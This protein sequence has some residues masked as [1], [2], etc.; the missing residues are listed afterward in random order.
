VGLGVE[1]HLPSPADHHRLPNGIENPFVITTLIAGLA[2]V[3]LSIIIILSIWILSKP[4]KNFQR[5]HGQ[6]CPSSLKKSLPT[7]EETRN[8]HIMIIPPVNYIQFPVANGCKPT[9]SSITPA[10]SMKQ[11]DPTFAKSV[12]ASPRKH[13][14]L[15]I[16]LP[17]ETPGNLVFLFY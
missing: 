6:G 8:N 17:K 15:L 9:V 3:T 12:E 5:D 4:T 2:G 7:T 14:T 11:Q 16:K 10:V 13:V 1:L